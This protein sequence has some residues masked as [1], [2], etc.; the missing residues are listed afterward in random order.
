MSLL[1][2][3]LLFIHFIFWC[4]SCHAFRSLIVPS[5]QR[6]SRIH[7]VNFNNFWMTTRANFTVCVTPQRPPDFTSRGGSRYWDEGDHVIRQAD[8]WSGQQGCDRIVDCFWYIDQKHDFEELL[9]GNCAYT[10]FIQ[11]KQKGRK[12]MQQRGAVIKE[13]DEKVDL[14]KIKIDFENFWRSTQAHFILHEYPRDRDPDFCSKSGS[15]YWHDGDG[16][17][18][19]SD[20]WTGQHG[21]TQIVDCRWTIDTVQ[22]LVKQPISGKCKYD[23]FT[24]RS[25]KRTKN[26]NWRKLSN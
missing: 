18:R 26:K 2:S 19:L 20:H 8:H 12:T 13:K 6:K 22:S 7:A 9:T 23:D 16:V 10:N 11:K 4:S 5:I 24:K 14:V 15:L 17:I 21:V 25:R 3:T 1:P